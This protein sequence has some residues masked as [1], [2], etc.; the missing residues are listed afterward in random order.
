MASSAPSPAASER[1]RLLRRADQVV[2]ALLVLAALAAAVAW[3]ISQGG[4]RSR[5]IEVDRAEPESAAFQVDINAADWPE[6]V[7]LPGVGKALAQRIVESRHTRGPFVDNE[8]LRRV[9]GIGPKT[10]ENIRPYLRPVPDG[11]NLAGK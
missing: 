7:Q 2:V 4:W 3:W 5:L 8:D 11:R 6:L 1:F 9:R 10:L